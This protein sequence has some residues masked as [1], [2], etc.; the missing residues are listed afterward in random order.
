MHEL[1]KKRG[2]DVSLNV[3]ERKIYDIIIIRS[4]DLKL[5]KQAIEH[6]PS[7]KIGILNP[8]DIGFTNKNSGKHT[9]IIRNVD[10]FIVMSFMWRDQLLKTGKRIYEVVDY[11]EMPPKNSLKVHTK[12]NDLIIGYHGNS[13]HYAHDFFPAGANALGKLAKEFN[14]TLKI[15]CDR[16]NKQPKI[17]GVNTEYYEWGIDTINDHAK[18]FDIGICPVFSRIEQNSKPFTY[19]RN[20]NR[21]N[22]LLSYGIP[23]VASPGFE[24]CHR[25]K[26]FETVMFAVSEHGWYDSLRALIIDPKLRN[27]IGESGREMVSK[28]FSTESGIESFVKV[29]EQETE[30]EAVQKCGINAKYLHSDRSLLQRYLGNTINHAIK[31]IKN[32]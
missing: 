22:Y 6:S 23:S 26:N 18:T 20:P 17:N 27:R 2:Y 4:Q 19:I 28:E 25:L 1:L 5:L 12:T 24:L 31:K 8:G 32:I 29:I 9:A 11:F 14:L 16:I 30:M 3:F 15:V 21:V 10:F 7:A 13:L